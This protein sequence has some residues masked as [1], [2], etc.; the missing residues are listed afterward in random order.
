MRALGCAVVCRLAPSG[1][2]LSSETLLRMR[3]D[4][5]EPRE[6]CRLLS[7][8]RSRWPLAGADIQSVWDLEIVFCLGLNGQDFLAPAGVFNDGNAFYMK[9]NSAP[10]VDSCCTRWCFSTFENIFGDP[11]RTFWPGFCCTGCEACRSR[12]FAFCL[13]STSWF[14]WSQA[15]RSEI[16]VNNPALR[17]CTLGTWTWVLRR[18][19]SCPVDMCSCS[20]RHMP[21]RDSDSAGNVVES[22][23]RADR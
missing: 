12:L 17:G 21:A 20:L 1:H 14:P 23:V 10:E 18:S 13:M 9:R 5:S 19:T 2:T 15:F 22:D 7:L 4:S 6:R 11:S 8:T 3:R 16:T